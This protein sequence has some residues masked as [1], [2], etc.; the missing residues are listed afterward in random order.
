MARPKAYAQPIENAG[1]FGLAASA[2]GRIDARDAHTRQPE[3]CGP[4]WHVNDKGV[5]IDH[6][7]HIAN[8]ALFLRPHRQKREQHGDQG[9]NQAHGSE[10]SAA[11]KSVAKLRR[12]DS[13]GGDRS[14][15]GIDPKLG[16]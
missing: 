12:T 9:D 16:D 6:P 11:T 2:L 15:T 14:G 13:G 1:P 5:P 7:D 3:G 4:I 10:T 8:V